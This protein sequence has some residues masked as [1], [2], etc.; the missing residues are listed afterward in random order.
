MFKAYV[1][2]LYGT[3]IN[4]NDIDRAAEKLYP[5]RGV[6]LGS[7]W[8]D[9]QNEYT[10]LRQIMG[11][12][13]PFN[14]IA[15]DSLRYAAGAAQIKLS[16]DA[17]RW[18]MEGYNHL[19][20]FADSAYLLQELKQKGYKTIILSNGSADMITPLLRNSGLEPYIDLA[21]S[22]DEIRQYKP[23]PAAYSL[24]LD[25]TGL[26]REDV[27]FIAAHGWDTSGAASFG[28]RT[29]WINR[30]GQ[31][32]EELQQPPNYELPSLA[33]VLPATTPPN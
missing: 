22:V 21:I 15:L 20:P 4:E 10:L 32:Q 24:V 13:R 6:L 19:P 8:R 29:A 7:I 5:G 14:E 11:R 12:Y 33:A 2:D 18:L 23:A 26:R 17:E 1:F 3:L 30:N 27:L 16:P 28:F 9:K 31:P 25:H